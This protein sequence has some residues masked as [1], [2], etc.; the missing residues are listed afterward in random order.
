MVQETLASDPPANVEL[1][2]PC[3]YVSFVHM[4]ADAH[5]VL[6]DSGGIQEE[7][8]A[9]GTPVLVVNPRTARQEGVEAGTA[10]IVGTDDDDIVSAAGRLLDDPAHH[11]RMARPHDAYGDGRAGERIAGVIAQL[12]HAPWQ[13]PAATG[14][15]AS[16]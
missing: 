12:A 1:L 14:D 8:P 6:T 15:R 9:L 4:L 10:T 2:E 5:L 13:E 11:A 7:A 3:D 16:A